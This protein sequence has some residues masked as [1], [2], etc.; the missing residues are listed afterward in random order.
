M[1]RGERETILDRYR[2]VAPSSANSGA[3]SARLSSGSRGNVAERA[4]LARAKQQSSYAAQR[5][6]QASLAASPAVR[7]AE[8]ATRGLRDLAA[9]D[10]QRAARYERTGAAISTA[11]GL[12]VSVGISIGLGCWWTP[13]C[14]YGWG[15]PWGCCYPFGA[16][17][18]YWW[19]CGGYGYSW[20]GHPFSS[21]YWY[22]YGYWPFGISYWYPNCYGY[23]Y[24][25]PLYY[26]T[27][28]YQYA[29]EAPA[30]AE[31][32]V[33]AVEQQPAQADYAGEGVAQGGTEQARLD[34]LLKSGPDSTTRASGQY[35]TLGD[36][37]FRDGR[38]ADAVHFYARA[39]E[40]APDEGVLYLVLADGLFATGDYHYGAFALRRALELDPTLAAGGIDK[41]SFYVETGQFDRQL[42]QL[43]TYLVDHPGDD[44]A[45]LMLAANYLFGGRPAASV[46]LLENPAS[47]RVRSQ[48]AG[49]LIL[50]AARNLQHGA[51]A[52]R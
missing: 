33:E 46:D 23:Y 22:W 26:S 1:G 10:P 7:R 41:R 4:A 28:V 32:V 8:S 17:W 50:E 42:A 19:G 48:P 5:R 12:G 39:V 40:F 21:C 36:R 9:V 2:R 15:Y 3:P 25:P 13:H 11:T 45:R 31:Q 47:E 34:R 29:E 52:K 18:S 6:N 20:F 27:V 37:A 30:E 35:L 43:E 24:S 14:G 51:P 16:G 44:D 38:Y 49:A